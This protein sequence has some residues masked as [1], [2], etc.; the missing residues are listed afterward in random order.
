ML[1]Q[2]ALDAAAARVQL[3][4]PLHFVAS[5]SS[6][7]N[8][9]RE[10]AAAG[11][12]HGSAVVAGEQHA[13]RGRLQRSWSGAAGAL[14]TTI[15]LRPE[16]PSRRV[17]CVSLAAAVALRELCGERFGIKWPNDLLGPDGRKVAGVLCELEMRRGAIDFVLVGIGLNLRHAPAD[18]PHAACLADY[19]AAV[20][21]TATAAARLVT[22]L[23]DAIGLLQRDPAQLL[24]RWRAGAVTL[25]QRVTIGGTEGEATGITTEGALIVTTDDGAA[26]VAHAGD[27]QHIGIQPSGIT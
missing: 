3:A 9:A 11:A 8:D 14:A 27:V 18:V 4:A 20:P 25:G 16:L 24:D 12:P 6:T 17:G 23:D 7:M 10:L 1:N 5:T 22:L 26:I 15:I 13:G 19:Q 21:E 2:A